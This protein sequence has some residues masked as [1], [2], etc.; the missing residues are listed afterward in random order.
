MRRISTGRRTQTLFVV[1]TRIDEAW[2]RGLTLTDE[3]YA[4]VVVVRDRE[5]AQAALYTEIRERLQAR[6]RVRIRARS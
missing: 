2:G 3:P 1:V 6:E 5:N 4:L